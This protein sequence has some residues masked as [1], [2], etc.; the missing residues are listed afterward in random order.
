M[1]SIEQKTIRNK[2]FFYLIKRIRIGKKYKK[3]QVYIGKSVPNDITG[4][5]RLMREKELELVPEI[6]KNIRLPD[7]NISLNE[8]S[9][10][11]ETRIAFEYEQYVLSKAML[12]RR[13]R[14]FAINFIFESNAIEGSKLSER[15]VEAIILNRYIKKTLERREVKEVKNAIEAF[16]LIRS[17]KFNLN[18][19]SII[20][21]HALITKN[22]GISRGYKTHKI[23]V[24][25]KLTTS[26]GLV[27]GEMAN[28][29][30]WWKKGKKKENPFYTAIIFHQRFERIHP[31]EDGNGRIGRLIFIWM[32]LKAGYGVILFKNKNRQAY[33][34]VLS[35]A[36]GG[37]SRA[38]FRFAMKIY[39]NTKF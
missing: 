34:S 2:R 18:Q 8:Y 13:W 24:N 23:V 10:V 7:K 17:G 30:S 33:F 5:L 15:E 20:A 27:R 12:K 39:K 31:F 25:N 16:N 28:L 35:K 26:P 9:S 19:R 3:I 32:L 11:E 36:D 38:W 4:E 1:Y 6:L 14:S 29:L 22:L 37:Q 21:L